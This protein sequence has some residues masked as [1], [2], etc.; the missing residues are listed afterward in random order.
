MDNIG[1][2]IYG[3]SYTGLKVAIAAP[4]TYEA[5]NGATIQYQAYQLVE[6]QILSTCQIRSFF[7]RMVI[8]SQAPATAVPALRI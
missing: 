5:V 2:Q 8:I 1:P 3:F 4:W 6:L 7:Q